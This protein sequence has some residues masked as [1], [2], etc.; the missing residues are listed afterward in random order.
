MS[1]FHDP[2]WFGSA[3]TW[4]M[5]CEAPVSATVVSSRRCQYVGRLL[6]AH[7]E[8]G[9]AVGTEGFDRRLV[10]LEEVVAS[11]HVPVVRVRSVVHDDDEMDVAR[12]AGA[13]QWQ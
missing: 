5:R 2:A 10:H 7:P 13:A 8:E 9:D 11:G 4:A 6:L 3:S 12:R 1:Q